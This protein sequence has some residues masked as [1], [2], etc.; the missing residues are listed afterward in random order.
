MEASEIVAFL[1][2][3]LV[4][5]GHS[6]NT[7]KNY[8]YDLADF[9]A[10][11]TERKA[12]TPK[13]SDRGA[14]MAYLVHCQRRGLHS[15]TIARRLASLR[16]FYRFLLI[17][18]VIETSPTVNLESPKLARYLPNVL[19]KEEVALLL[20]Q[21]DI[22]TTGGLRDKAMLETMYGTGM[23]VSELLGLNL[24]DV[25]FHFHYV[26]CYGKGGRER[27]LPIGSYALSALE[28]YLANSRPKLLAEKK[29][30]ALFLNARGGRLSRQSYWGAIKRYGGAAKLGE[31]VSPHTLR[32]SIAAHL[33][34]NGADLRTVQ[35]FL[36]HADI[37]TTQ[38][39]TQL[40]QGKLAQEFKRCHPR[41]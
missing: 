33:L 5:K 17:D 36:G 19:T 34:E 20:A 24:D 14:V 40:L 30:P 31:V 8:A 13:D 16:S 35:E 22:T 29:T 1:D 9:S 26:K 37:S 2:Y 25:N 7:I 27:L 4:E 32:H 6:M 10:F 21:P 12:G 41:S 39:Y 15:R 28:M 38:I 11:L 3:L 18:K 23:R